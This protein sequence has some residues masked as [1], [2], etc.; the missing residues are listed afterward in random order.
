MVADTFF[1]LFCLWM[2]DGIGAGIQWSRRHKNTHAHQ[3]RF[4]LAYSNTSILFVG[5]QA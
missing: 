1:F 4:L 5:H 2:V 3:R